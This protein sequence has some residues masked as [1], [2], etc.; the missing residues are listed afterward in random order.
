MIL[1]DEEN[2]VKGLAFMIG[3]FHIPHSEVIPMTD[4]AEALVWLGREQADIIIVDINMP[5]ISGLNFIEE[6][7]KT[8]PCRFVILSGYSDFSYA[9][10]AIHLRVKE[11]LVKPVDEAT[12]YRIISDVFREI[13]H[14]APEDYRE[15][16][17]LAL[18]PEFCDFDGTGAHYSKHMGEILKFIHKNISG[19]VSAVRLGDAT[20]LH[21]AYISS[22][23]VKEMGMGLRQYVQTLRLMKAMQMLTD[24]TNLSIAGIAAAL[25]YTNERQF[26]RMFKK[27]TSMT[28]GQFR[29][30]K[31]PPIKIGTKPQLLPN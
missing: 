1:D 11:Y 18:T 23:F 24:G 10:R 27:L 6:A 8:G 30:E 16:S 26:F 31:N 28:P 22:L 19:D 2:I 21:P 13:Y 17:S 3:K 15:L 4:P 9:Q 29:N 14:I 5:G 7:Q 12:L 25:G 20:G